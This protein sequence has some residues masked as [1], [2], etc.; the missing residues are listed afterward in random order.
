MT[1]EKKQEFTLRITQA[2]QSQLVVILYEL[3]FSY[4]EEAKTAIEAGEKD[5]FS[6]AVGKSH[7]CLLELIGSLK[8]E[9]PLAQ[10]LYQI[11]L[12]VSRQ[13]GL[14]NGKKTYEPLIDAERLMRKLYESYKKDSVNDT[15]GPVMKQAQTVYAGLTYGR[16][17]VN[18]NMA[19]PD[20]N[21][22]FWA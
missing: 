12:F 13:I 8:M 1:D 7:D 17:D 16:S 21:R 15:S 20:A 19:D 9:Q 10:N 4:L 18:E 11:Y 22:G 3:F 2:N 14:A 6:K 5:A